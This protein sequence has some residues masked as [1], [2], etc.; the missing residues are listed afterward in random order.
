MKEKFEQNL[1]KEP[2]NEEDAEKLVKAALGEDVFEEAGQRQEPKSV[3]AAATKKEEA[4]KDYRPYIYKEIDRLGKELVAAKRGFREAGSRE[5]K[6]EYLKKVKFFREELEKA[7][8]VR[9]KI[10]AEEGLAPTP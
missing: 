1:N 7:K 6:A 2:F 8:A 5:E 10:K 3:G 9:D 4:P